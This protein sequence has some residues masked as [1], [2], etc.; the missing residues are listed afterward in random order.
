MPRNV[1]FITVAV[2]LRRKS[3]TKETFASVFLPMYF[4]AIL[5][6]VRKKRAGGGALPLQ[7]CSDYFFAAAFSA[8]SFSDSSLIFWSVSFMGAHPYQCM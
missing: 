8:L 1:Q 5:S 2:R 6:P 4:R 7:R 3:R